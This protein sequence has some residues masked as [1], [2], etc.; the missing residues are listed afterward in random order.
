MRIR[1]ATSTDAAIIADFNARMAWETEQ[2]RL[3]TKRVRA[4]VRALLRN[5][6]RGVYFV[7]Q[8]QQNGKR[9]VV[10]QILIT[11]EW[12]DWRNG[13]FWWIQSVYVA[14]EFR[15]QG[16]FR[17]LFRHVNDLA[18]ARKDVCGLRLYVD[19]QNQSARQAYERLGMK[20]TNYQ[21]FEIDFVL[22][23]H[24]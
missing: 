2:R 24:E 18:K 12:S 22:Q 11:Y 4:G 6:S 21:L 14:E 10:G 15:G 5:R 8:E 16:I 20:R 3:D 9:S 23:T 1:K 7:A 17:A 13:N 19:A